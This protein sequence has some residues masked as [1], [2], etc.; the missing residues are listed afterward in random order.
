MSIAMLARVTLLQIE[1]SSLLLISD[2]IFPISQLQRFALGKV[3]G[4]Q[5]LIQLKI[6]VI[7]K[8]LSKVEKG[9]GRS[10]LARVYR[11]A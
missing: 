3:L 8:P 1:R 5:G 2:R 6:A 4:I 10:L 7:S 9:Q 11:V